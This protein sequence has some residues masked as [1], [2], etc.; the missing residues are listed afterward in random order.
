MVESANLLCRGGNIISRGGI[1]LSRLIMPFPELNEESDQYD[2]LNFVLPSYP[3]DPGSTVNDLRSGLAVTGLEWA[4]ST[5]PGRFV[6]T[7]DSMGGSVASDDL[8]Q[9][10]EV[11]YCCRVILDTLPIPSASQGVMAKLQS[12]GGPYTG[13]QL[14]VFNN[15]GNS[16]FYMTSFGSGASGQ[17]QGPPITTGVQ[18]DVVVVHGP[19]NYRLYVNKTEVASGTYAQPII[20]NTEPFVIGMDSFGLRGQCRIWDVRVYSAV[21][22]PTLVNAFTDSP[23]DLFV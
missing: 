3:S 8:L 13:W 12:D 1:L 5:P 16:A 14:I 20:Q 6:V 11:S 18:Y 17:I 23:N 7:P 19:G 2:N 4:S 9:P 10:A 21:L 15:A 22:T